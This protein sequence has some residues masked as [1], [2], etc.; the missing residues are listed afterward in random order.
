M[1]KEKM[2]FD[3]T[4]EIHLDCI[5]TGEPIEECEDCAPTI[6]DLQ[7]E[8]DYWKRQAAIKDEECMRL[9][10]MFQKGVSL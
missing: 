3:L 10:Q 2:R 9:R 5:V 6:E 4:K 7:R 8:V 1:S